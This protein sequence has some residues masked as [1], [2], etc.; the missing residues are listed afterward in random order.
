MQ[1]IGRRTGIGSL[2]VI[3]MVV[4]G[5]ASMR[6]SRDGQIE[7]I[8]V[9]WLKQPGNESQRQQLIE[10]SKTFTQIPGVLRVSAGQVLPSTRPGVESGFDVAVVITFASEQALR[11]YDEHPIHKKAVQELLAPLSAKFVIY[12]FRVK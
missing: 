1:N 10:R 9:V 11:E 3:L 5:C 4:D 6:P 7:H 12:D 2:I 8:V